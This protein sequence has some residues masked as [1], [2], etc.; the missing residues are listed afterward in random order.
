VAAEF[1][2]IDAGGT[3]LRFAR[4]IAGRLAD[5]RVHKTDAFRTLGE[6]LAF[7]FPQGVQRGSGVFIA[8]AAAPR[9]GKARLTNAD[10]E[11]DCAALE[12]QY[13]DVR[14]HLLND[15]EALAH[16]LKAPSPSALVLRSGVAEVGGPQA[17]IAP[18]TGL[19]AAFVRRR[20]GE[21]I[22]ATEA[23]H[24]TAAPPREDMLPL[25]QTLMKRK[26]R[27]AA[28]NLLSGPGLVNIWSA[29]AQQAGKAHAFEV[30]MTTQ[31]I[32][33]GARARPQSLEGRTVDI[34][35]ALLGSF[36]GDCALAYGA[37]G[38]VY[39]AGSLLN[40]MSDLIATKPFLDGFEQKGPM[41]GFVA[42][43]PVSLLTAKEP[44]LEGLLAYATRTSQ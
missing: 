7:Q 31:E 22:Q 9:D 5:I 26:G 39:L 18:G 29:L 41:S 2:L 34:Y 16:V 27:L 8:V 17:V 37:R 3:N 13:P 42:P 11:V 19:G 20:S 25:F 36:A 44:V 40:A 15:I 24:M 6:A 23:G 12:A 10:L 32:I 30:P 21:F 33:E 4:A 14:F 1:L 43:I 35:A 28:E 38:G